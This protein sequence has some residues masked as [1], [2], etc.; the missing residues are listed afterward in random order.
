MK[1]VM[2]ANKREFTDSGE[3]LKVVENS[4]KGKIK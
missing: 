2:G 1:T 4:C 3:W